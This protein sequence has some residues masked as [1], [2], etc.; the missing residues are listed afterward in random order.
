MWGVSVTGV[1]LYNG[2][3]AEGVDPFYPAVY[4]TVTDPAAVVEKVD[5]CIAHPQA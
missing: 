2:I 4:G 5:W 1:Q 3:S